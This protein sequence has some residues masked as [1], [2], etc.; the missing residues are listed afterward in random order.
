MLERYGKIREVSIA[1]RAQLRS[2]VK[3]M[4][5]AMGHDLTDL[6]DE[7]CLGCGRRSRTAQVMN[8]TGKQAL[9]V[10]ARAKRNVAHHLK[11]RTA[12]R[13]GKSARKGVGGPKESRK[14]DCILLRHFRLVRVLVLLKVTN[15]AAD[16]S[17][18]KVD[19]ELV[20]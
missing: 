12:L 6:A 18:Q 11:H 9:D 8:P 4:G 5:M 7:F 13:V 20:G 2:K 1:V 15:E 3:A 19:N 17:L 16:S 14:T 10:I